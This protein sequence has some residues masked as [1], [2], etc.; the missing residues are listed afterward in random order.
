MTTEAEQHLHQVNEEIRTFREGAILKLQTALNEYLS[1]I[2][3]TQ[4]PEGMNRRTK[5]LLPYERKESIVGLVNSSME[6]LALAVQYKGHPC[7]F[8]TLKGTSE[9][10]FALVPKGSK[11]ALLARNHLSDFLP[12][13]LM[14]ASRPVEALEFGE[15]VLDHRSRGK[16]SERE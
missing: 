14:D 5:D 10:R 11:S 2:A 6:P 9:G 3:Q 8:T 16:T 12:L 13:E 7:Y 1:E 15:Q 4:I